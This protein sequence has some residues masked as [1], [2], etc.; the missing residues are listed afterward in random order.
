MRIGRVYRGFVLLITAVLIATLTGGCGTKYD[1]NEDKENRTL[2]D[3]YRL[4]WRRYNTEGKF[5][6]L[7]CRTRPFLRSSIMKGDTASAFYS[8]VFIAQAFLFHENTDSVQHYLKMISEWAHSEADPSIMTIYENVHGSWALKAGLDYPEAL[9][10][11]LSALNYAE[12]AG[13][14]NNMVTILSNIVMLKK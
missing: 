11:Y 8:G 4:L 13:N 9:T 2:L 3:D 5:D 12:K 7:I 10:H 14:I 6:S 1:K